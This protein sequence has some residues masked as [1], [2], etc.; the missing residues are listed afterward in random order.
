MISFVSVSK[1][2]KDA[3]NSCGEQSWPIGAVILLQDEFIGAWRA[4][5][6]IQISSRDVIVSLLSSFTK[7]LGLAF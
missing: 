7:K 2:A 6:H 4:T 1:I 3:R 5:T